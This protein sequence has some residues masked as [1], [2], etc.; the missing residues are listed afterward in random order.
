MWHYMLLAVTVWTALVL[1]KT[2]GTVN[3]AAIMEDIRAAP[4][5]QVKLLR[6]QIADSELLS[7]VAEL[8]TT[9][10]NKNTDDVIYDPL[11]LK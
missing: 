9:N 11:V 3:P 4:R 7:V 10:R 5:Y 6:D 8:S 1:A 2:G